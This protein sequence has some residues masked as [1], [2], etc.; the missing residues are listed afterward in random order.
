M[1]QP[2]AATDRRRTVREWRAFRRLS[3]KEIAYRMG[4]HLSTYANMEDHPEEIKMK[5]AHQLSAIFGCEIHDIIFF[6]QES[7]IK[8][9]ILV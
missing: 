4:V 9:E 6:E 1:D 5:H 2:R 3:K 8:L 7:N